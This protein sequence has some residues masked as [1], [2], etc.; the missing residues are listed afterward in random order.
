M[1]RSTISALKSEKFDDG[2]EQTALRLA[3]HPQQE[4]E[5]M[6]NVTYPPP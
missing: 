3:G 1:E 4:K 2:L 5:Y 6:I